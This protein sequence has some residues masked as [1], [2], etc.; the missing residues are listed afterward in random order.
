MITVLIVGTFHSHSKK[1]TLCLFLAGL[2][3]GIL[4]GRTKKLGR[5][6][7]VLLGTT[8]HLVAFLLIYMNFPANAPL[9]KTDDSGGILKPK[10]VLSSVIHNV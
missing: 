7:I 6:S 8:V 10:L 1:K 3:F 2:I 4:D 5:D 9:E